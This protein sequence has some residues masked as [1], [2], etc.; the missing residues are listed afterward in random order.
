MTITLF[1]SIIGGTLAGGK[2][3]LVDILS[4]CAQIANGNVNPDELLDK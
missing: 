2:S 4:L 3:R 1:L